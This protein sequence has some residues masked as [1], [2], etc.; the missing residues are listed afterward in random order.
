MSH[1]RGN[2][3]PEEQ[4]YSSQTSIQNQVWD[5]YCT[6]YIPELMR[7][8]FS[9]NKPFT[10]S[11]I[12]FKL[13]MARLRC[14]IV[15]NT[16]PD[17]DQTSLSEQ[18]LKDYCTHELVSLEEYDRIADFVRSAGHFGEFNDGI[19]A[20][21]EANI[22]QQGEWGETVVALFNN[23]VKK[24]AFNNT[25]NNTNQNQS[26]MRGLSRIDSTMFG[27]AGAWSFHTNSPHYELHHPA[28]QFIHELDP[29]FQELKN[30]RSFAAFCQNCALLVYELSNF[31]PVNRGSAAVNAWLCRSLAKEKFGIEFDILPPKY[32]WFAFYETAEQYKV[33][34]IIHIA[35]KLLQTSPAAAERNKS[36]LESIQAK[37]LLDPLEKENRDIREEIWIELS[38]RLTESI[39]LDDLPHDLKERQAELAKVNLSY[40]KPS[41]DI[42]DFVVNECVAIEALET[43]Q[44]EGYLSNLPAVLQAYLNDLYKLD[45]NLPKTQFQVY[46]KEPS[47]SADLNNLWAD[48]E[49]LRRHNGMYYKIRKAMWRRIQKMENSSNAE[50][51]LRKYQYLARDTQKIIPYVQDQTITLDSFREPEKS[52]I[53]DEL[54]KGR[55]LE[56]L[57][58][59]VEA[60]ELLGLSAD[61]FLILTMPAARYLYHQIPEISPRTLK[62]STP[63]E[64]KRNLLTEIFRQH[65][66][67]TREEIS[68][69]VIDII[70]DQHHLLTTHSIQLT[71]L[72]SDTTELTMRKALHLYLSE[73]L[74]DEQAVKSANDLTT[75]EVKHWLERLKAILPTTFTPLHRVK[76]CYQR[77]GINFE[78]FLL[79]N[80]SSVNLSEILTLD[81]E[82]ITKIRLKLRREIDNAIIERAIKSLPCPEKLIQRATTYF[83]SLLDQSMTIE[84]IITLLQHWQPPTNDEA[85]NYDL[86]GAVLKC[87]H[88][89]IATLT[90]TEEAMQGKT[91]AYLTRLKHDDEE[92]LFEELMQLLLRLSTTPSIE[93]FS[94]YIT[95]LDQSDCAYLKLGFHDY[96]NHHTKYIA[97]HDN[98]WN[99]IT[100]SPNLSPKLKP[101]SRDELSMLLKDYIF[102]YDAPFVPFNYYD[103]STFNLR[104]GFYADKNTI[105]EI[106]SIRRTTTKSHLKANSSLIW[107]QLNEVDSSN[108]KDEFSEQNMP[109]KPQ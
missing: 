89:R 2:H 67:S 72:I 99:L 37:L 27:Y 57:I 107:Q 73:C 81:D 35:I 58:A 93:T 66:E 1:N 3:K 15:K 5:Y 85:E 69:S 55:V 28:G 12:Y 7:T 24:D 20:S 17:S 78:E 39:A 29:F 88:H 90:G 6:T 56:V 84:T 51:M 63:T 74:G 76:H 10:L 23:R 45:F 77:L 40:S 71:P 32:D 101:I 34:F 18:D 70:L 42:I 80:K 98:K 82:K 105:E 104:I 103:D 52:V 30:E 95:E 100:L 94:F 92:K 46:C 41:R 62:G 65:G 91:D 96:M 11:S 47:K 49:H 13:S 25:N 9:Q 54:L 60:E 59:G 83:S 87:L 31:F 109:K 44:I 48:L 38:S 36:F 16:I 68:E 22:D 19:I 108:K 50:F 33:Y 79:L 97:F 21:Y 106:K 102:N 53:S 75:T 14:E 64:T 86:S 8:I 61:D 43:E 4:R 26:I